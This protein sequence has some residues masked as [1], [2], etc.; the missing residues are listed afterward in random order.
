MNG[1][2][3]VSKLLTVTIYYRPKEPRWPHFLGINPIKISWNDPL[4]EGLLAPAIIASAS[5]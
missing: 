3:G 1:W 2:I 4:N 5:T